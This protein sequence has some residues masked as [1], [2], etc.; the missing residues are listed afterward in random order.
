MFEKLVASIKAKKQ[1][2][3]A[4]RE[5]DKKLQELLNKQYPSKYVFKGTCTKEVVEDGLKYSYPHIEYF[6]ANGTRSGV[7]AFKRLTGEKSFGSDVLI[8]SKEPIQ[9]SSIVGDY[10]KVEDNGVVYRISTQD[11]N[12]SFY[13]FA[14]NYYETLG[15]FIDNAKYVNS[16]AKSRARQQA[17]YDKQ[18][19]EEFQGKRCNI[20]EYK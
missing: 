2:Q 7:T 3:S 18:I 5:R 19:A 10:F 9:V 6:L 1:A 15:Y 13:N 20:Y 4:R 17:E 12:S 8:L 16:L 14:Q 11:A